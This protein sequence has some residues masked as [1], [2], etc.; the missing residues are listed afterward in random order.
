MFNFLKDKL[1]NAISKFKK[2]IEGEPR[3][4]IK[5]EPK[6]EK[7]PAEKKP[8][9]AKKQA[10]AKKPAEKKKIAEPKPKQIP[11][12]K[13]EPKPVEYRA[14]PAKQ[15]IEPGI[16]QEIKRE[17]KQEIKPA[18]PEEGPAEKKSF[19]SRIKETFTGRKEPEKEEKIAEKEEKVAEPAPKKHEE[20]PEAKKPEE[21]ELEERKE[22][23]TKEEEKEEAKEEPE[24][25]AITDKAVKEIEPEPEP[26]PESEPEPATEKKGFFEKIAEAVTTKPLSDE[27]FEELFWELEVGMLEA[28]VAVEVIEKIKDD[29][30]KNLVNTKIKF[31]KAGDIIVSSLEKSVDELF[32]VENIDL[33]SRIKAKKPYI[34]CFFGVNGSGK[35]T[36]IAKLC[37]VLQKNNVS[38]VIAAADTFRAAAIH[39]LEE[40]AKKLDVKLI[41]HDYG[42]DPAAVAF[43]AVEHAKSKGKD[44]VLIDTAGRQHSNTNLVDEMKKI[45]RVVKPDLKIFVGDSLTGNDVVEQSKTFDQ[46]VGIDAIILT[47][48][49][50]DEKGGAAL[51]VSFVTG[52]PIIYIGMGQAYD[53]L[54]PFDKT[55]VIKSLGLEA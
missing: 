32:N 13:P 47:K 2:T 20:K 42:A 51:S 40:H 53:D 55:I 49:D 37:H 1:K 46:A 7:K 39:Q 15:E 22:I 12:K 8:A 50:V 26:E 41:K 27:K 17:T 29:L 38:V 3:E 31:G 35:T 4:E 23:E 34:V 54:K 6:Q 48:A 18:R 43:D 44:V 52:K 36:S 16:N 21:A 33:L 25:E 5:P 9:D 24:P 28:N 14:K 10:E 11:S 19:F 30:R 45:I